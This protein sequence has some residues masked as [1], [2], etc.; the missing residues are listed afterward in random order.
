[1]RILFYISFLVLVGLSSFGCQGSDESSKKSSDNSFPEDSQFEVSEGSSGSSKTISTA[2][3]PPGDGRVMFVDVS[4]DLGVV[5]K[6]VSGD[7][8]QSYV[9]DAMM[10]GSALFDYDNDGDLDLYVLNGSRVVGFP[11]GD[12]PRNA[13]YRNDGNTFI[14]VTEKSGTGD[15]G[16]GMGCVTGDYNN[17]GD[18][19]IYVTNYG[20][21]VLYSNQGD[22]TFKDVT[23][24][25]KVGDEGLSTGCA[26]FDYDGDGDLDL[27]VANYIDFNH[28]LE[29][30]PD[31][32]Y[33]WKGLK[34]HFGPRGI[35]GDGDILYRN[36][37]DGT[38]SDV[39][40]EAKVVGEKMLY[41]L[42]VICG[43]YDNDGD[44]DIYVANDTGPNFLYQNNGDGTFT[45][46]GWMIG[47]AYSAYGE[48]Q[49]CMG[50]A[51][52][53]Y[54]NDGYQ[55]IFVTNFWE[56]TNTLYH[57][58]K[59][60]FFSDVSFDG[61]VAIES[62]EFLAWGTGFFDYDNDGDKD[63]FVANG[64]IFPQLDRANLGTSYAQT[65]Q[66]FENLGDG[67]F[68][69]VSENSGA[70]LQI[71]KVSRGASFGDYDNDGD[72]DI[73]VLDL[74]DTPTFLRNEGG[75][76]NNWL[77]VKTVGVQSNRDGIGARIKVSCGELTQINEV[78]SGSSY[79]SQNDLRVHFGLGKSNTVDLLEVIWPSGLVERFE[80][81]SVN[82]LVV[83][84]EGS[85]IIKGSTFSAISR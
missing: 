15:E 41:G 63:L 45:D 66:L 34:V 5:L 29:T 85:G 82:Q 59:G 61:G 64:H 2:K 37:G 47:A 10:G 20:K 31:R 46:V 16:W 83:V 48:A 4:S 65:N 77:M 57:N 26:F 25:A 44:Q 22:G 18:L 73:F 43:D 27:Y 50:I 76:R 55:D 69:D 38:F 8:E 70:G 51:F 39:T 68:E 6:N 23:E 40:E 62:F 49:G 24:R 71:K 11:D 30:T 32:S 60:A 78:R 13:L 72:I 9:V 21:N 28:F 56:Q 3:S 19:D 53:D 42:G 12:H 33:R 74:N 54:D 80:N 7:S 52:G 17:D 1:M 79:L 35:N 58:D 36:E 81:L 75:N 67:T 14:D 84:Q